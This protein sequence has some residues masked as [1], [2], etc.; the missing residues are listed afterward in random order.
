MGE[1]PLDDRHLFDQ[2]YKA[3]LTTTVG[4]GEWIHFIDLADQP[5]PGRPGGLDELRVSWTTARLCQLPLFNLA[6]FRQPPTITPGAA[7]LYQP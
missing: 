5:R 7:A 2:R 1:Y 4:A 6:L 3:H